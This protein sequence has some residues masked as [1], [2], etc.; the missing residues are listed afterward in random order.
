MNIDMEDQKEDD[1]E[2]GMTFNSV[3]TGTE[4]EKIVSILSSIITKK[5]HSSEFI[6]MADVKVK[7]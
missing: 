3:I 2:E 4:S 5:Q 1:K 7:T 6:P